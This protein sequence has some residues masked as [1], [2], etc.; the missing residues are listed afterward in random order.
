MTHG[1]QRHNVEASQRNQSTPA[2]QPDLARELSQVI[3]PM[4]VSRLLA[5]EE[6][7]WEWTRELSQ[8]CEIL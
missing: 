8:R 7:A 4:A 6:R 3:A 5:N 2:V 1:M